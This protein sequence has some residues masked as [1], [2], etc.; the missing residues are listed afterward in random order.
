MRI[1]ISQEGQKT[2]GRER[3]NKSEKP[4]QGW[5]RDR[6]DQKVRRCSMDEPSVSYVL[7][8]RIKPK[9]R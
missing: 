8:L 5:G 7:D 1:A 4:G 9:Y 3:K 6:R 2:T